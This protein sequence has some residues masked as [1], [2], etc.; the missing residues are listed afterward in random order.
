MKCFLSGLVVFACLSLTPFSAY[1]EDGGFYLE[2]KIGMSSQQVERRIVTKEALT[3]DFG[4]RLNARHVNLG[5]FSHGSF[6]GGLAVGYDFFPSM[7][8]PLRAEIEFIARAYKD[9]KENHKTNLSVTDSNGDTASEEI[10]VNE[11]SEI[12]IHTALLNLYYDF[13]NSSVFTPFVGAGVGLAVLHGKLRRA[14]ITAPNLQAEFETDAEGDYG[15]AQ[16]AW[17]LGAGVNYAINQDWSLDLSYKYTNAGNNSYT[18]DIA[19]IGLETKIQLHDVMFGVR[20][21]F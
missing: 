19:D 4:D 14:D 3:S 13:H 5:D 15:D 18:A 7:G 12:G 10:R 20:Y 17:A 6:G 21:T 2:A 9:V 1:G 8:W 16:F 11:H